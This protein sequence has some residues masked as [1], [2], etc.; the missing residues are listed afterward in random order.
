MKLSTLTTL[1]IVSLL[2]LSGCGVKPVPHKDDAVDSSL[3]IV[4]LTENGTFSDM[5]AIGFEWKTISDPR[6]DGIYIYKLDPTLNADERQMTYYS[7]ID[8]RFATHYVDEKIKPSTSY[9]YVFKTFSKDAKSKP[10]RTISVTSL[11]T[12]DS[13]S[14]IHSTTG[15]PRTAKIIWRPHS[16]EKVTTYIIQRQELN[17]KEFQEIGRVE[18]RLNVEFIDQDLEDNHVYNY[19][20]KVLTYDKLLS[21]PSKIVNVITKPLPSKVTNISASFNLPKKINLT[22]DKYSNDDFS[23]YCVYRAEHK[24][25]SYKLIAK[26]H[27]NHHTDIRDEDS[28]EYY[29]KV[30]IVDVD[31]LESKYETTYVVGSTLSKPKAPVSVKAKLVANKIEISWSNADK[32]TQKYMIK[33]VEKQGWLSEIDIK[34]ENI[35]SPIYFDSDI[36][37]DTTYSYKVYAIDSNSLVSEASKEVVVKTPESKKVISVKDAKPKE[38]VKV[39]K[40]ENIDIQTETITPIQDLDLNEI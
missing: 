22:W 10:S 26:L 19:R 28:K 7:T 34:L 38:E 16:N 17:E 14:W 1:W 21:S 39:L 4:Q 27:N 25:D 2:I 6:V 13:V 23:Y 15:M 12:L 24:D 20:I 29:Y 37:P 32:K 8:N 3:P 9:K 11:A 33:K 5:N 36:K 31:G 18:G 30:S 40:Q 35:K